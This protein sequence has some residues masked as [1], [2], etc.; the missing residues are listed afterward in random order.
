MSDGSNNTSKPSSGF[1]DLATYGNIDNALYTG[2]KEGSYFFTRETRK[3]T[4]FTQIP[5]KLN[6]TAANP[7]FG[8]T[9]EA[10][11]SRSGDYLL[12]TW[13]RVTVPGLTVSTVATSA[14]ENTKTINYTPNLMHNL[15]RR[16][17]LT[18]NDMV[19]DELY[20]EFFDVWAAFMIPQSKRSGY[21][22]AIGNFSE[23]QGPM[24]GLSG[25]SSSPNSSGSSHTL[26]LPLPFFFSRD[27]STALPTASL[28]Y[29]DIKMKFSFRD[30]NELVCVHSVSGVCTQA[31]VSDTNGLTSAPALK[32]VQVWGNYAI[33]NNQER[34]RMGCTPR[35]ILI[36][37]VQKV[38]DENNAGILSK[39][40]INDNTEIDL[41][42]SKPVKTLYFCA[43]NMSSRNSPY[44]SNYSTNS[45]PQANS[46]DT[47]FGNAGFLSY[48][49]SGSQDPI[50][51]V[52]ILYENT[53]RMDLEGSYF[54]IIQPHSHATNTP[55]ASVHQSK[56]QGICSDDGFTF[57]SV[58]GMGDPYENPEMIGLHTDLT[59]GYHMYS[60]ALDSSG[61]Q[62]SGSTNYDRLTNVSMVFQPS[63]AA[64][65]SNAIDYA[66]QILAVNHNILRVDKGAAGFPLL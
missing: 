11:V 64:V 49:V 12:N 45:G 38:N 59:K 48:N 19:A 4:W 22:A 10:V 7:N 20:S 8:E 5:I 50:R 16:C 37:Q 23:N 39:N 40:S 63:Q 13:L 58:K 60:Y 14:S 30:W 56:C 35:D 18:F 31:T 47:S 66:I 42:L 27:T 34:K 26:Y 52:R 1:I 2:S 9:F 15:L 44:R 53:E 3:S 32:N 21:N 28:P 65:S 61:I 24:R 41:R 62:P 29:N 55:V 51:Q 57:K 46:T 6:L 33:V 36:E 25:S 43:R 17:R 54:N